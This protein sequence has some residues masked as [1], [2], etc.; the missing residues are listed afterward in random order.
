MKK[1]ERDEQTLKKKYYN[2]L[3]E[4]KNIKNR[5]VNIDHTVQHRQKDNDKAIV[6]IDDLSNKLKEN[7]SMLKNRKERETSTFMI[8]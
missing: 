2:C 3:L 1:N 4:F 7:R 6:R 5:I 8:T